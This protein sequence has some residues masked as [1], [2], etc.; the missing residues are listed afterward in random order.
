[1]SSS[2][3]CSIQTSLNSPRWCVRG[4]AHSPPAR[5]LLSTPQ[6]T[7]HSMR[8]SAALLLFCLV[9]GSASAQQEPIKLWPG[10]SLGSASPETV[11]LGPEGEH[12]LS[13]I[14]E[15]SILPYLP[16]ADVATG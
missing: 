3:H 12:I 16:H 14:Q 1:M 5:A 11:R 10:S 7:R 8:A 2:M 4:S 6:P 13:N 9:C 15:P